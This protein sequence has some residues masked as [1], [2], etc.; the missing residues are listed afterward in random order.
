M[1]M[2]PVASHD[3]RRAPPPP[4]PDGAVP[5]LQ[6]AGIEKSYGLLR[7]RPALRGVSLRVARGEC[8][9]LAGP[10]GAGKTTLIRALC[11]LVPLAATPPGPRQDQPLPPPRPPQPSASIYITIPGAGVLVVGVAAYPGADGDL[12]RRHGRRNTAR[13]DSY[14]VAVLHD[15]DRGVVEPEQQAGHA[16]LNL[17]ADRFGVQ[18]SVTDESGEWMSGGDWV[19]PHLPVLLHVH[20]RSRFAETHA[21]RLSRSRHHQRSTL[22]DL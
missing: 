4:Q 9:G 19:H 1:P 22:G 17:A 15:D 20:G 10:N 18:E 14:V 7:P 13:D 6:L 3:E 2:P 21:K 8:Y 5:A 11:G 16:S 12:I